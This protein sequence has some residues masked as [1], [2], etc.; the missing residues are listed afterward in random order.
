MPARNRDLATLADIIEPADHGLDEATAARVRAVV[1]ARARD[2]QDLQML[3]DAL[4][5]GPRAG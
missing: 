1:A 3:L 5:L 4:G 2:A